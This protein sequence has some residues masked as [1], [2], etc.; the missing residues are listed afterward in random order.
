MRPVTTAQRAFALSS[1]LKALANIC[2]KGD[3][4]VVSVVPGLFASVDPQLRITAVEVSALICGK[5]NPHAVVAVVG[6]LR[7]E[8]W[9]LCSASAHKPKPH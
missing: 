8:D 2:E 3:P 9:H 1:A 7:N 5:G 4:H 6:L